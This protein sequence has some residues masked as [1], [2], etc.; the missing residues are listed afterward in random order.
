MTAI[1]IEEFL[2]KGDTVQ[3]GGCYMRGQ[4]SNFMSAEIRKHGSF[5]KSIYM[6]SQKTGM[7]IKNVALVYGNQIATISDS[8]T[9]SSMEDIVDENGSGE[10]ERGCKKHN[11]LKHPFPLF[12]VDLYPILI[13]I[14]CSA[15]LTD[16]I[17][18]SFVFVVEYENL[19]IPKK[20]PEEIIYRDY[21]GQPIVYKTTRLRAKDAAK[22]FLLS[23]ML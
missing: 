4:S 22:T 15:S 11:L 23:S 8:P 21:L 7:L 16:E 19:Q 2:G 18:G 6:I 9:I 17:D 10:P 12:F 20:I 3:L 14:E 1:R 5:I 13:S